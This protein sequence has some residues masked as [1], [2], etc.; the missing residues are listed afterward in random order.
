MP[1][2]KNKPS[3]IRRVMRFD[4]PTLDE[5]IFAAQGLVDD[6]DGQMEIAV[7]L[8]GLTEAEVRAAVLKAT[9]PAAR[10]STRL[11]P[12]TPANGRPTVVV[13]QRMTRTLMR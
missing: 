10:T 9:V 11:P 7:R 5:A 2:R 12:S 13:E 3:T 1:T 4:P 6:V 8:M